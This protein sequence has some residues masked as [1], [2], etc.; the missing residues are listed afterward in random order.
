MLRDGYML[1]N[2]NILRDNIMIFA[3]IGVRMWHFLGTLSRNSLFE[4]KAED[5]MLF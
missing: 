5:G 1:N 2:N 4:P 3:R